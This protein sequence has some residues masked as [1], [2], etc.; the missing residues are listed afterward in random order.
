MKHRAWTLLELMVVLAIT[1]A[2]ALVTAP[3]MVGY[4]A[5]QRWRAFCTE[6]VGHLTLA[7]E[8]AQR[9]EASVQFSVIEGPG[10]QFIYI[11][12]GEP[13]ALVSPTPFPHGIEVRL[14]E[15]PLPH[16][17]RAGPLDKALSS[18]HAPR[19]VFARHGSS[20][21]SLVF[22]DRHGHVLCAVLASQYG[23]LRCYEWIGNDWVLL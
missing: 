18:T 12:E 2:A 13:R 21:A 23:R 15:M 5:N 6:M 14:P 20:S 8:V 22:C 10:Y 16:P 4:V 19:V 1:L 17:S 11:E 3:M 9:L 7:R